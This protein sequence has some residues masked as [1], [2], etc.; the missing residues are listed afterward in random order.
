[1][2][3]LAGRN[4]S[5]LSSP[6]EDDRVEREHDWYKY[7]LDLPVVRPPGGDL[8]VYCTASLIM[9]GGIVEQVSGMCTADI[10]ERYIARPLQFGRYYLALAPTGQVHSGGGA[11]LRP[12]DSLNSASST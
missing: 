8:A 12:R 3:P 11:Y 6:G 5:S 4:T 1:M 7:I 10:F 9:V 2:D